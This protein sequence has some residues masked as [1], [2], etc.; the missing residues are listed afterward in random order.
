M[1]ILR[2]SLIISL[3]SLVPAFPATVAA[4][5]SVS[6]SVS[7]ERTVTFRPSL[8][9]QPQ[10]GV[11]LTVGEVSARHLVSPAVALNLGYRFTPSF[12]LRAGL[13]GWQARGGWVAPV[14]YYKFDYLQGNVDAMLSFTS[15]F[16]G[17]N[18]DR[19]IDFY[20]FAGVGLACGFHNSEAADLYAEGFRFEKL[21]TGKHLFPA[22]RVGLGLDINLSN[23]FA[24]NLEVNANV[25]PD[26]FN[27]R[28]GSAVDWQYNALVGVKYT[29]GGRARITETRTEE[30]VETVASTPASAP[31]P[32]PQPAPDPAPV[33]AATPDS[34]TQDIFF[35]INSSV[36]SQAEQSKVDALVNYLKENPGTTVTVT[37]Y[38]DKATGYPAYNMK[39]STARA[40][41]VA[42]ALKAAGIQDSRIIVDAKG[43]TVQ[44]F[45]TP[46]RNR[47]AIAITR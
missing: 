18:P 9:L 27:S 2:K 8:F 38:A 10:A 1:K 32:A 13:S 20:G 5:T 30:V 45:D 36:I 34:M 31:A 42:D 33:V 37:G 28:Q 12:G 22:G 23:S 44:P 41:R 47:V 25:L 29:F 4:Q 17:W 39:L 21:W 24:L 14:R 7:V 35:R 11:G 16:C 15:L 46:Q 26:R 3:L 19:V 6:R 43:D 40:Q